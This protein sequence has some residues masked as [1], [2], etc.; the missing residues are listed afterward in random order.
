MAYARRV[1]SLAGDD[2]EDGAVMMVE[3]E[4]V[5][6]EALAT[7]AEGLQLH[8]SRSS[9]SGYKGVVQ[10]S[11]RRFEAISICDD[12]YTQNSIGLFDSALEAAVAYA[13]TVGPPPAPPPVPAEA[14]GV[15][16]HLSSKNATG[17]LGVYKNG[18]RSEAGINNAKLR[19]A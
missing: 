13:R 17:Y 2:G 15:R 12:G 5:V 3:A 19:D 7:E 8:L 18:Q 1:Q 4:D 11:T 6:H 16:L 10:K 14:E 9:K